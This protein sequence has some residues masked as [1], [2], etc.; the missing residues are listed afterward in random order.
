[1]DA[2]FIGEVMYQLLDKLV[3]GLEAGDVIR[4]FEGVEGVQHLNF[5]K[6]FYF[7]SRCYH[8]PR[9]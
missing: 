2:N 7:L 4:R 1:M 8:I 9:E 6:Y 5:N 3:M